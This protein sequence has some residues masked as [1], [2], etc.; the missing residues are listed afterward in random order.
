MKIIL[1]YFLFSVFIFGESNVNQMKEK[2]KK[3]DTEIKVK[4]ERIE[5]INDTQKTIEEQIEEIKKEIDEI[6][7]DRSKIELEIKS[8][9]KNIDY[10]ERN[11]KFSSKELQRTKSEFDAK[12]IAWNRRGKSKL[13]FEEEGILKRQFSKIL[14]N[15]LNRM[16]K[17]K[18][19]THDIKE[20][21]AN[22]EK[23]RKKLAGL[24]YSL[25]LKKRQIA[26]KQYE[27][28]RLI[29]K[30]EKEKKSHINKI[31]SLEKQKKRIEKE[32][33]NI[34]NSRIKNVGE[35]KYS[36]AVSNLGRAVYPLTNGKVV[37]NFND[38]KNKSISSNGIEIKG[39]LGDVVRS[40]FK[41][42]I[43]Y[44]GK[45]QGLGKV[46]MVDYGYNT[47]GVYGNLISSKVSQN[48]KVIQ[49]QR[50]GILGYS[51]DKKPNLYYEIRMNLKPIDP[52]KFLK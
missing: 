27:K 32:I 42:E 17:I 8:I 24:K 36:T 13:S 43:I 46:I 31:S 20:V 47:I 29:E 45:I 34:I 33:E 5:A 23:E 16:T 26:K 40:S 14:Y 49:G 28:N 22:I 10:G 25:N 37:L 30:L 38:L 11:L 6:L 4:H 7:K 12:I 2:I 39:N 48:Q 21:K 1:I 9:M 19:V 3:L 51:I 18:D 52:M 35:V 41:G 44:S 15:D 50:I